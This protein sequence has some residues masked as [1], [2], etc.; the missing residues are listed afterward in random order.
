MDYNH[1]MYEMFNSSDASFSILIWV[2]HDINDQSCVLANTLKL[3]VPR[4]IIF[5]KALRRLGTDIVSESLKINSRIFGKA[6]SGE[7]NQWTLL[8]DS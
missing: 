7:K 5:A 1:G 2:Y 6:F 3:E 4:R 8:G